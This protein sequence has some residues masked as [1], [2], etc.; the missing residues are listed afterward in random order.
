MYAHTNPDGSAY[1]PPP[2]RKMQDA[3]GGIL[4]M[5]ALLRKSPHI[6]HWP[7]Y[8]LLPPWQIADHHGIADETVWPIFE[9]AFS[10]H[11]I[12]RARGHGLAIWR[13]WTPPQMVLLVRIYVLLVDATID[14]LF[15]NGIK[16]SMFLE[17]WP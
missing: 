16:L 10:T 1:V 17:D 13:N 5:F 11:K 2:A 4:F 9:A 12:G 7:T 8:A 14:I 3:E 6:E 15:Y